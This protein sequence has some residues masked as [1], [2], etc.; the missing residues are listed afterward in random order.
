[1]A[2]YGIF[3]GWG[4]S[5]V[6]REVAASRLFEEAVAY[7]SGLKASGEIEALDLVLLGAHGGDLGGF[8]L[9]QGE[10]EKLA[11]LRMAPEWQRLVM[12]GGIC[13]D[14]LGVVDAQVNGGVLRSMQQWN[15]AIADLV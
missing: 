9:L 6:G 12:R 11:R 4:A 1:M 10:P 7:W 14:G 13:L 5:R 2:D 8:A 15:E 3:I